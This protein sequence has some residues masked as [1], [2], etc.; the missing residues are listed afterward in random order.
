MMTQIVNWRKLHHNQDAAGAS[1]QEYELYGMMG[2]MGS[3]LQASPLSPLMGNE[4]MVMANTGLH[5]QDFRPDTAA[6]LQAVQQQ[7]GMV[8]SD[9]RPDTAAALQAV[10]QSMAP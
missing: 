7:S 1:V 4:H 6:A 5:Q 2:D 9:Y 3:P 8:D 10:Q